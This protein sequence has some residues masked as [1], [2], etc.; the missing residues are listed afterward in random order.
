M[1]VRWAACGPGA[2]TLFL[3]VMGLPGT[4]EAVPRQFWVGTWTT[5]P[6]QTDVHRNFTHETLRQIL[7]TSIGGTRA[8]I[9]ISN[10]FGKRPLLV[11]DVYLA[12]SGGGSSIIPG[13]DRVLRFHGRASVTSLP[14]KA[15]ISDPVVFRVHP[16][17]DVAVSMYLPGPTGAPTFNPSAHQ[18]NYI[19]A[20]EV[21]G[22]ASLPQATTTGSWYYATNLYVEGRGLR[23]AVVTLGASITNGYKSTDNTNQRWPDLLAKRVAAAHL[24]VGVLN[25]GISAL[26]LTDAP[27]RSHD[28]H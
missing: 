7:H 17:S 21:S 14:G 24:K 25:Q 6:A 22:R 3:A 20:G 8:R 16:L 12:R 27:I 11:E 5:P 19:A 9:R 15:A 13:S 18:T 23:G 4:A 26:E 28:F 10:L 2:I 1:N